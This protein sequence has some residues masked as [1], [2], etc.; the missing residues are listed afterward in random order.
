MTTIL[1]NTEKQGDPQCQAGGWQTETMA[2]RRYQNGSIRKRGKRD[3]VWELQWWT[4]YIAEDGAIRRKRDSMIL[5]RV[6]EIGRRQASKL[7][8]EHLRPLNLGKITPLS[9]MTF[10]SFVERYF[11]PNALPTL[12]P[13]TQSCY[14]RTLKTHLQPA[15]GKSRLCDMTTL[16]IQR[17]V[18]AKMDAGLGWACC[19]HYRNLLSKIFATAKKWGYFSGDN[20]ALGVELPEKRAVREKHALSPDQ[21][22]RLLSLFEEPMRTMFLVAIMTGMRV[23]EVLGLRRKDVD[24]TAEEICVEQNS[25][26]GLIGT[27][28]T[29]GSRRTLPLPEGPRE[30]L[31]RL[32]GYYT[33]RSGEGLVFHTRS[34][35]PYSDTNL[36]HREL[37]P[38]GAKIGAPWLNWHTLRRTHCTLFQVAGGSLRD[39]Q[40]QLGHSKMSTTLEVYTIPIDSHRREVVEKL[41]QLVT[42]GDEFRFKEQN[43]RMS[44]TQIQ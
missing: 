7:A 26:R 28:K 18:L 2:R 40:A 41:G 1:L 3:P 14:R 11:I 44:T 35:K 43:L 20:P 4:D 17:F 16:E 15:F 8:D 21:I 37:K 9:T 39:A 36:L 31:K 13:S 30:A 33:E 38:A 24:F 42:N 19:D 23:G 6:S 32:A 25:Y 12:K 22:S 5:G 27:P 29:K 34:G 10:E